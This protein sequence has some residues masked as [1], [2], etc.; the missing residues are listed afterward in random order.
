LVLA[1]V[2]ASLEASQVFD[3]ISPDAWNADGHDLLSLS[4]DIVIFD[5]GSVQPRFFCDL[6]QQWS[7]LLIGINPDS[8]QVL[9]WAGQQM[10]ELSVQDLVAVIH[11]H[12]SHSELFIRNEE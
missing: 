1:S 6:F 11:Q 5:T 4:P 12:Q 10:C 7:G 9:L 8:N 3:V 2:R